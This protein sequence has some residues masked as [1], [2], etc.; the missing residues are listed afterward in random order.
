MSWLAEK[1]RTSRGMTEA[2]ETTLGQLGGVF[3]IVLAMGIGFVALRLWDPAPI[4]V[5]RLKTFDVFQ[6]LEPR[7]NSD[8]PVV[9]VDIDAESLAAYGQWPWPRTQVA[10]LVRAILN[11]GA[12]VVGLDILFAEP[13]RTSPGIVAD[14]LR[15]VDDGIRDV[16]RGL[17]DNDQAFAEVLSAGPVVLGVATKTWD[18]GESERPPVTKANILMKG[19]DPRPW[20][21]E[22][23]GLTRPLPRL[24]AAARGLAML[25]F[26]PDPDGI[27]RRVPLLMRFGETVYPALAIEMLRVFMQA[28]LIV[29]RSGEIGV[30]SVRIADFEIPTDEHG[31]TWVAFAPRNRDRYVSAKEVLEG[32]V[33]PERLANKLVLV[34]TSAVGLLDIKQTPISGA[35]PGVEVHAQLLETIGTEAYLSRPADAWFV[36]ILLIIGVCIGMAIVNPLLGAIG[37][38]VLQVTLMAGLLGSSWY[39]YTT[40][41]TLLGVVYPVTVGFIVYC[42]ITYW[43]YL[44][45]EAQQRQVR[46]AFSHYMSTELVDQLAANPEKMQLGGEVKDLTVMFCD[47]R[48][49]TAMSE[50]LAA[51]PKRLTAILNRYFNAMTDRITECRGTIDKYI[52]DAIMAF[53]NAPLDD[54]DHVRHACEG[55]LELL[56]GLNKLDRKLRAAAEAEGHPHTPINIGIGLNSGDCLV[57]NMGSAQRFN[58]S[59]IGDPCNL[60]SRLEGQTKTYGVIIVI[61]E[62]TQARVPDFATLELDLIR[63][64]GKK[65]AARV[66]ALL[67]NPSVAESSEFR[68]LHQS[69]EKMLEAYRSQDW[70]TALTHIEDCRKLDG[71]LERLYDLYR[72]R[73]NEYRVHSPGAD[74][75]GVYV[76]V[77][78]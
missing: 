28:P 74:W 22:V 68:A 35:M 9:I 17:P 41:G 26:K 12:L 19:G 77:S 72:Y 64:Q 49:F 42:V 5:A 58:Y 7:A 15:G 65:E 46:D 69:H 4:E 13:D 10:D 2:T 8:T 27:V 45:K 25:S 43:N 1:F 14:S 29:V 51:D 63:V 59:V 6:Q 31:R 3:A 53:W 62:N 56:D 21:F 24:E 75:D 54:P 60:A 44:R 11:Q 37:G 67:G 57:G 73:V 40:N 38:L 52:G 70:D 36:D 47:M 30:E 34:G 48:N 71:N 20:L 32:S 66:F 39:L 50:K 55:A 23:P 33:P 76:A 78:K 18:E 16:L 61:G